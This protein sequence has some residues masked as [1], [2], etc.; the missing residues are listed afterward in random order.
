MVWFC[1]ALEQKQNPNAVIDALKM[2]EDSIRQPNKDQKFLVAMDD[3]S[4][5]R[6]SPTEEAASSINEQPTDNLNQVCL[7]DKLLVSLSY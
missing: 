4:E 5:M 1:S 3:E 6:K 7:V 2:Y